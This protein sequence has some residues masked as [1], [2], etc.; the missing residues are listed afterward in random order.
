MGAYRTIDGAIVEKDVPDK[1]VTGV[2]NICI[3][4]IE[5]KDLHYSVTVFPN[6]I[7]TM[8][9]SPP[10]G[11]LPDELFVEVQKIFRATPALLIGS[12]FSCGYGL[13]GMWDLGVHLLANVEAA[14]TT[15]EAKALWRGASNAVKADLEAGLNTIPQGAT[16]REE[17]VHAIRYETAKLILSATSVA[18]K[19]ILDQGLAGGHAPARLLRLL[20]NGAAQN[21]ESIPVITTNYD[22][23]LELF[24]DL[25]DLPIDTGFTGFRR[26]KPRTAPIFQT[27]Y[28]RVWAAEKKGGFQ[29]DHR[30]FRTVRLHKP[31]GSISWLATPTGPVE[32]LND[33]SNAARAI[34]VPG[35]SKYQDALVNTLFDAMRTEMNG[36]LGGASA[37]LCLGFGFNDDHLQ[38]VIRA[39]L[40]AHMPMILLTRDP[41]E[42][43]NRLL[44]AYPHAIAI[45]KEDAGAKCVWNGRVY[46]SEEP[47]WQLDDFLKKFLE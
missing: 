6:L 17:L 36:V 41:T 15:D 12:G 1:P 28:S 45:F 44:R 43:I 9:T 19:T 13:P 3:A 38:G 31:H 26:R 21:A 30:P 37:L 2:R 8:S 35:P 34:V 25:A 23:L 22:T 5:L 32:A 39:R 47:L 46:S 24:C 4:V 42:S 20:F 29:A 7:A 10:E 11:T 40:D 18:E 14:L 16:G 33:N 27:Q